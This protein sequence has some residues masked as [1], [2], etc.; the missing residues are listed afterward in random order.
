L[1]ED[2]M[3]E[4]TIHVEGM[5]CQHCVMRVKKAVE[6]L[7]GIASADV[8]IGRVTVTFDDSKIQKKAIE[9]VIVK[10]GYKIKA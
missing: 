6:G 9:D 3:T 10:T 2:E 8:Q 7:T 4:T 1:E 5:S